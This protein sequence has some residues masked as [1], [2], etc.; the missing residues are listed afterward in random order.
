MT[1]FPNTVNIIDMKSIKRYWPVIEDA[2][3]NECDNGNWIRYSDYMQLYKKYIR[4]R[5]TVNKNKIKTKIKNK[6]NLN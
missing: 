1:I 5:S 4:A 2:V 6:Y 3:M